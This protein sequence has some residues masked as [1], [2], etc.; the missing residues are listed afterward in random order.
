MN[1]YNIRDINEVI[2][3]VIRNAGSSLETGIDDRILDKSFAYV[4]LGTRYAS[5]VERTNGSFIYTDLSRHSQIKIPSN[6]IPTL[7]KNF[8]DMIIDKKEPLEADKNG[9][10]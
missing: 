5:I 8:P 9:R 10:E 6:L 1:N 4:R 7:Q 3:G 2:T